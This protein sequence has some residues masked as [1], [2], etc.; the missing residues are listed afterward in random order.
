MGQPFNQSGICLGNPG[1]RDAVLATAAAAPTGVLP[2]PPY[3][4]GQRAIMVD[5]IWGPG[6]FIFAKAG[7]AIRQ[8]GLCTITPTLN[9][10]TR[11]Y[12]P[13][14]AEVAN[15]ANLAG[16]VYVAQCA[17]AMAAN[18]YGWF[19]VSG[20]TPINGTA[21]VAAGSPV[22]IT[23]AG[24]VGASSAGKEVQGAVSVVGAA[25]TLVKASVSGVSGDTKIQLANVDGLFVGGY[26]AG[27]GVGAS[28][29]ISAI[30]YINNVI[31]VTV[32][33]SAAV[34]G[35]VTMTPNNAT[36]FYNVCLIE[37]PSAQGRIT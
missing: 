2:W 15:T 27:T 24:Q 5:P 16:P 8:F 12:E 36:I 11:C 32:A 23:A 35:N 37:A 10:T 18:Q 22:G 28:A 6:E 21:T 26:V 34:T 9:A 7:G 17:G 4:L 19:M 29:I 14:A 13:T 31:T 3:P 33:N 1:V 30:D 20:L 25:T